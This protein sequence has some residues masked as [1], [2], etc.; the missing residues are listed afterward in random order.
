MTSLNPRET[1]SARPPAPSSSAAA[2]PRPSRLLAAIYHDIGMAAVAECLKLSLDGLDAE[3][4]ES[5][6]RGSR[7]IF[8][9]PKRPD[10]TKA[11]E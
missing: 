3:A 7:Y 9:M 2:S 8:L 6:K 5:I 11:A 10:A 4:H 1:A